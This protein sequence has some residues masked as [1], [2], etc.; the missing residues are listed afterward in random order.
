MEQYNFDWNELYH[1][2][3]NGLASRQIKKKKD[4]NLPIRNNWDFNLPIHLTLLWNISVY[5]LSNK[6]RAFISIGRNCSGSVWS[7]NRKRMCWKE[8]MCEE[9]VCEKN[10]AH[11]WKSLDWKLKNS[12]VI[13]LTT[14][15]FSFITSN[16]LIKTNHIWSHGVNYELQRQQIPMHVHGS[17]SM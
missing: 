7:E 12:W 6:K 5:T 14:V 15:Y 13:R 2:G 8:K 16:V 4:F 9:C 11:F 10:V 1:F 3:L 17:Y